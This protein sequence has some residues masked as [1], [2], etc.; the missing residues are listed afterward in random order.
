MSEA[1]W[2]IVVAGIV[3]ISLGV[4]A[5]FS[6]RAKL[7]YGTEKAAE[8]VIKAAEVE[9]KI[10]L[11]TIKLDA[12]TATT[13]SVESKA[14]TIVHQT[15]GSADALR[16]L[17]ARIADRVE[18]LE[19]SMAERVTK[20]EEYNRSS[21]HRVLD[22]INAVHLKLAEISALTK[23]ATTPLHSSKSEGQ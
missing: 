23:I 10:D 21:S 17:V 20:L 1:T 3:Q 13:V 22:A 8:A 12:N 11:N 6:L 5:Y 7:R 14:D 18:K 19:G 2:T 15:N 16:Q 9:D 4:L